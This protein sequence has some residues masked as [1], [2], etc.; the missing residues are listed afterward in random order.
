MQTSSTQAACRTCDRPWAEGAFYANCSECKECKRQRSR[1][2][3]AAQA[4]KLA[5]AERLID[6]LSVLVSRVDHTDANR[7]RPGAATPDAGP[8][9]PHL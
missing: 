8:R 5:V 2:N 6:V 9:I 3:R 4:R 1:Q 7:T